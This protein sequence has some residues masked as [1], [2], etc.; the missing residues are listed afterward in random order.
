M[1]K[2][3]LLV[4]LVLLVCSFASLRAQSGNDTLNTL[5]VSEKAQGFQLLFNGKDLA[6]WRAVMKDTPPDHGW[7]VENGILHVLP[8]DGSMGNGGGDLVSVQQ[9]SAF[10]LDFDFKYTEGANSGVKYFVMDSA[11][12]PKSGLG[13]EYQILD[14][15]HHPDAKLGTGG[16]RTLASLYDLI[17]SD[18]S[19]RGVQRRIGE[20]NRGKIVVYPNNLVQHWLN[21]SKVLEYMRGGDVFNKLIAHSKYAGIKSFGLGTKG[22]ILLQEHGSSVYFANIKIRE[23]K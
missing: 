11:A 3:G 17:P 19:A 20:W 9:F 18:K 16:D 5:S 15:A 23:L 2:F 21:G 6:G 14:D 13:L 7:V 4:H 10:E 12:T 1:K 8:T 22:P